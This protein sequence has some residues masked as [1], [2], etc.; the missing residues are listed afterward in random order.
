MS[1]LINTS[2]PVERIRVWDVG[3]RLFHWSLVAMVTTTYIFDSPRS[4]HR[5]LGYVV[6]ALIAFRIVWGFIGTRHARFADF[7]PG[8]RGFV[9]YMNDML[10]GNEARY[11]GHNPAG[12]AMILALLTTLA[13]IGAT[14]YMMGM[15]A[16]F[17][18]EW[19]EEAHEF[20]VNS[21]II[22]VVLH[23]GGVIF[24]SVR[25][26]ENLVVSMITGQKISDDNDPKS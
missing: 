8:P 24:S 11:V 21:L 12:G 18:K 4:L 7:V 16:Y 20:L 9:G 10:R 15:D 25:H 1:S 26:R 14:G 6:L 3:V 2:L 5:S 17:G 19:V 23:V 13:A 22:L